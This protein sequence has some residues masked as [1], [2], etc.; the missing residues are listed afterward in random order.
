[1]EAPFC[2]CGQGRMILLMAKTEKN[3]EKYFFRC[4]ARQEHHRCFIW[5][6]DVHHQYSSQPSQTTFWNGHGN[7][8]QTTADSGHATEYS[9]TAGTWTQ[10]MTNN[11]GNTDSACL[12]LFF[13]LGLFC[14][15]AILKILGL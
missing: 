4:P 14:C 2:Y 1:M 5:A 9:E 8:S 15:V 11:S 6:D 3:Y 7:S 13:V 12:L 10:P